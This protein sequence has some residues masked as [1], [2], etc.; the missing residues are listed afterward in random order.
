MVALCILVN[1]FH[2]FAV[3]FYS[4]SVIDYQYLHPVA[5]YL[6]WGSQ[7]CFLFAVARPDSWYDLR[8]CFSCHKIKKIAENTVEKWCCGISLALLS[9]LCFKHLLRSQV[10]INFHS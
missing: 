10:Q 3:S 5:C 7:N 9:V 4:I 6:F 8:F 1:F 2:V